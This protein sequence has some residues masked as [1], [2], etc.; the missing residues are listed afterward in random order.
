MNSFSINSNV[1]DFFKFLE[2]FQPIIVVLKIS[3]N[4]TKT[5]V[6]TWGPQKKNPM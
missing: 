1:F 5:K 2:N 3:E 6:T 4:S